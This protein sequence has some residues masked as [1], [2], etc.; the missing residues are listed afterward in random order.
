MTKRILAVG[1]IRPG[2]RDT[3]EMTVSTPSLAEYLERIRSKPR[4]LGTEVFFV[5]DE[6]LMLK[7]QAEDDIANEEF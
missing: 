4:S 5:P 3:I 1:R 6:D 2:I 7:Q